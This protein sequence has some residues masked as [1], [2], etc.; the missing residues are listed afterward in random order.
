M[1]MGNRLEDN[2]PAIRVFG[3]R[4]GESPNIKTH[5]GF[6]GS[7]YQ[8]VTG[9]VQTTDATANVSLT[10]STITI[11]VQTAFICKAR[12]VASRVPT[13]ERAGYEVTISGLRQAGG[14]I[15]TG[16]A[17]ADYTAETGGAGTWAATIG[18]GVTEGTVEIQV[19]GQ[20]A[21]TINWAGT[22]EFQFIGQATT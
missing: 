21:T 17:Q 7:D 18:G 20:A 11:P 2:I 8:K 5:D 13:A 4:T 6:P 19:T 16:A 1:G 14:I 22:L 12:V 15:F 9:A 3:F 10:G